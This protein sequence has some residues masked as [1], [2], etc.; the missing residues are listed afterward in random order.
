MSVPAICLQRY[1]RALIIQMMCRT[2]VTLIILNESPISGLTVFVFLIMHSLP[3]YF[4]S[5]NNDDHRILEQN[6]YK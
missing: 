3:H 4:K 1:S 5:V 6:S 2:S